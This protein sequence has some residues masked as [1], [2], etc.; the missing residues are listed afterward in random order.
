[1]KK[2]VLFCHVCFPSVT[3]FAS[4]RALKFSLAAQHMANVAMIRTHRTCV[5]L[6]LS[7]MYNGLV[8]HTAGICKRV[9]SLV[10]CVSRGLSWCAY[11]WNIAIK[12][13]TPFALRMCQIRAHYLCRSL[14]LGFNCSRPCEPSSRGCGHACLDR[15]GATAHRSS[16]A[17]LADLRHVLQAS[18][19]QYRRFEFTSSWPRNRFR[20]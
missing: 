15:C 12:T 6:V 18:C 13:T 20:P 16:W 10:S 8:Q 7:L 17:Q 19:Y 2:L 11:P 9:V 1:M 14:G 3:H 4:H 5:A